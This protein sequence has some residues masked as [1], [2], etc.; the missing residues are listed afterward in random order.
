MDFTYCRTWAGSAT[1]RS[2]ST[3]S[4]SGS[5]AGTPPRPK[6]AELVLTPLRIAL[7]DRDRAG[8]APEAWQLTAHSD[9]GAQ[10]VSV[11]FTE[12]LAL[13]GIHPSIGTVG[14]STTRRWSRSS[15]CSRPSA[16]AP[17]CSTLART[18]RSPM[19][20]TPSPA[21]STGQPPAAA[22]Q[23][24]DGPARRVR[25]RPLRCPHPRGRPHM[26]AADMPGRF[27][28]GEL[29]LQGNR[30]TWL[31]GQFPD[32]P[33]HSTRPFC[34]AHKAAAARVETLIFV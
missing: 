9:A 12:R 26:R 5:S 27:S 2:S 10:Y 15:G 16:S 4:P 21:G 7:W 1:S 3:A 31:D 24:R 14:H 25:A 18:R 8:H 20:N 32:L 28:V 34:I 13:E 22:L 6:P 29:S 23:H 33:P 17:P 11:A 30:T 19:S